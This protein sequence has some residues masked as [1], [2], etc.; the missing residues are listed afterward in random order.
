LSSGEASVKV[1]TTS[2]A[3]SAAPRKCCEQYP[4]LL[5]EG[6]SPEV[7]APLLVPVV[8]EELANEAGCLN[9]KPIIEA[10]LELLGELFPD[11]LDC[12]SDIRR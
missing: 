3:R 4:C 7:I 12:V 5:A 8:A 10:P 6:E 9:I 1:M 2:N 11:N